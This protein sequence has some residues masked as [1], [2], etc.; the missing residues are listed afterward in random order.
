MGRSAKVTRG[1]N[2]HRVNPGRQKAKLEQAGIKSHSALHA[3]QQLAA[4]K[5]TPGAPT[6]K[7]LVA[8]SLKAIQRQR[9]MQA[10]Q[11]TVV[12]MAAR[13]ASKVVKIAPAA[14]PAGEQPMK[15]D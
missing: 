4:G 11:S 1:G 8:D 9:E 6:A 14:K 12:K 15:S 5:K 2:K 13:P 3:V 10:E 7:Q